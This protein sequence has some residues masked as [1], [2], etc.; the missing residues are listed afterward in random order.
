MLY[1]RGVERFERCKFAFPAPCAPTEG[2]VPDSIWLLLQRFKM[3]DGERPMRKN[4]TVLLD[5]E[6]QL[7]FGHSV[8]E[9]SRVR[10]NLKLA[11]PG[12]LLLEFLD[13]KIARTRALDWVSP[14]QRRATAASAATRSPHPRGRGA[15]LARSPRPRTRY[16]SCRQRRQ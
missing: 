6:E 11:L 1:S 15:W 10:D 12:C 3:T 5:A 14:W 16:R 8:G 13:A 9:M 4:D 2:G 7:V